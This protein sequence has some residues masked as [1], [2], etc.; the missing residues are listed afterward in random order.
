MKI[1]C[2]SSYLKK[3][4]VLIKVRK[5]ISNGEYVTNQATIECFGSCTVLAPK[6]RFFSSCLGDTSVEHME[7]IRLH[8]MKPMKTFVKPAFCRF[9]LRHGPLGIQCKW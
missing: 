1:H 6:S 5:L 2:F 8:R 3:I 9:V 7:K 4:Q